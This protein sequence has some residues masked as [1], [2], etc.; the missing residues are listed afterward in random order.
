MGLPA[1][2]RFADNTR[3]I[4]HFFFI[5]LSLGSEEDFGMKFCHIIDLSFH[6]CIMSDT[7]TQLMQK[8]LLSFS[9]FAKG[10]FSEE[11]TSHHYLDLVT[12]V[13]LKFR[14]M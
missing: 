1:G 11:K 10:F 9:L 2:G 8:T 6:K 4:L 5:L 14:G 13:L 7:S 12:E 3:N